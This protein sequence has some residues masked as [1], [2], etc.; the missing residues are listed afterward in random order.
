MR[1]RQEGQGQSGAGSRKDGT[2]GEASRVRRI[3][4]CKEPEEN[5]SGNR[6]RK[7]KGTL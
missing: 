6:D 3:Q 7:G 2:E 4:L 5:V 1:E